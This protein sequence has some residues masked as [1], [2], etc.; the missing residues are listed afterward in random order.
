M[1]KLIETYDA[2]TLRALRINL[3]AG[4]GASD[5]TYGDHGDTILPGEGGDYTNW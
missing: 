3:E 4:F 2:P 5:L 1:K